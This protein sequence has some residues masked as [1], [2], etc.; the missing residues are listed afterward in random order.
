M[1]LNNILVGCCWRK[2]KY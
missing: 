1:T 2:P